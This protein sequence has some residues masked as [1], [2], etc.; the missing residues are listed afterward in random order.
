MSQPA[1]PTFTFPGG[2]LWLGTGTPSHFWKPAPWGQ[3]LRLPNQAVFPPYSPIRNLLKEESPDQTADQAQHGSRAESQENSQ[4]SAL[5]PDRFPE[6]TDGGQAGDIKGDKDRE[7][8]NL[9][10]AH[11][12]KDLSGPERLSQHDHREFFS[13]QAEASRPR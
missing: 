9:G 10:F 11:D 6:G 13:Q 8:H 2:P 12:R 7:D 3:V 5:S 1:S 4:K